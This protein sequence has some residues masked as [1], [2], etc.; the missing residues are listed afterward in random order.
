M[1]SRFRRF[2]LAPENVAAIALSLACLAG[3]NKDSHPP[4][5]QVAAKI[6]DAEITVYQ[7]NSVLARV[8]NLPPEV[9]EQA[10]REVLDKLIDQQLAVEQA[11]DQKLDRTPDVVTAIDA[12]RRE[13]LSR[14]YL[15]QV[16][17]AQAKPSVDEAKK[18]Y[19]EHPQL[20]AQRRVYQLREIVLPPQALPI[21][22]LREAVAGKTLEQVSDWLKQQKLNATIN[23]VVRPAEQVA[24]DVLPQLSE[25]K[26]GQTA[27]L[28]STQ[29]V[30]VV[31][32]TTSVAEPVEEAIALP[33]IQQYLGNSRAKA[34][35][36]ETLKQLKAKARIE[37]V[38]DFA[39]A[40]QTPANLAPSNIEKGVAGLR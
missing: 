26:D 31:R 38:G 22:K 3:C 10:R 15:E 20:F 36:E 24:L 28:A 5:S 39:K 7:V 4:A 18:Y 37:Y 14:A 12:A 13:I 9:A 1:M 8:P 17:A 23:A 16:A 32:V 6:N 40:A 19:A 21:D 29:S 27:V 35:I 30:S 25:L 2:H 34:T 11:V 33:S